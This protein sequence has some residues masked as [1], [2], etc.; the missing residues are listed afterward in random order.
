MHDLRHLSS[1]FLIPGDF[2]SAAPYGSG[3][4]NDTYAVVF[5]QAGTEIR[6]IF[7]RIN[8]K[9]FPNPGGLMENV[10]RVCAHSQ[11]KLLA[12]NSDDVSRRSLTLL[13]TRAGGNWLVDGEDHWR[14][15]PFIE[16]AQ[17]YDAIQNEEQATKAAGAFGRFQGLLA[18]LPGK[19]LIETIPDF[20]HT[21]RRYEKLIAA[22]EADPHGR[23]ARV[24]EEMDFA[25]RR[26][27]DTGI[28]V[29]ALESGRVPERI[30]HNDT[31]L[32]NVMIDDASGEGICVI[33]LDT[34]M[35][36]TALNDFGDM[37][38]TATNPAREDT[39]D[40]SE[41]RMRIEYFTAIARGYLDG[42]EDFLTD[43]ERELLPV[44][45]KLMTLECGLRF[46]TDFLEG[47]VYFKTHRDGHN[48]DRCRTQF[49]LVT[50]IEDQMDEMKRQLDALGA[51]S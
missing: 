10:E 51:V 11:A 38:R 12:A 6:Y 16:G 42:T 43:A 31:K 8:H 44:A 37:I 17:T 36:G 39:E 49:R 27:A 24:S 33:D 13:P 29:D 25:R 1:Q 45:G 50:S 15:Y 22:Y 21:R 28:I 7:Q 41:V 34:V 48:L 3:H 32:N 40:L 2:R 26:E 4:I 46:L 23:A 14:C 20:H 18:D 5:S 35:P 47:D 9:V 19:R 30:T